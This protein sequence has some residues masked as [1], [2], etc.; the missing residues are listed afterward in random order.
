METFDKAVKSFSVRE[1]IV[2][3]T[4]N[5]QE[6]ALQKGITLIEYVPDE[7]TAFADPNSVQIVVRNLITNAIKFSGKGDIIEVSARQDEDNI[8]IRIRDTGQGMTAEQS[9]KLFKSKVDSKIGT[10]NEQGTGMGLLFCKDLVEKCN[11]RIWVKSKQGMGSE[12]SFTVPM[13]SQPGVE[14]R[15]LVTS[16]Q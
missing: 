13:A 14:H 3:E 6:Q 7:L 11:G 1:V 12:F 10:S 15:E 16:V 4:G 5:Y 2:G 8:L 9:H